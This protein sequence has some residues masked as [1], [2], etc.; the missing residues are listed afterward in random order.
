MNTQTAIT[1]TA[2]REH[3]V[4]Q[5][6]ERLALGE[7][8]QEHDLVFPS[9]IGTPLEPRNALHRFK[10]LLKKAGLPDQ[11]FH[12]LRHCAASLLLAQGS[13]RSR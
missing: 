9:S 11:P 8:W 3:R 13:C 7:R 12:N 4:R 10:Q 1:I 5:L 6:E 2:L